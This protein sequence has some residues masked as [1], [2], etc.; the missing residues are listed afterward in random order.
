MLLLFVSSFKLIWIKLASRFAACRLYWLSSHMPVIASSGGITRYQV[1]TVPEEWDSSLINSGKSLKRWH[2]GDITGSVPY[3]DV[4]RS[5]LFEVERPSNGAD[6]VFELPLRVPVEQRRLPHVHVSQENYLDVGL[7]HLRHLGHDDAGSSP[8]KGKL[9][10]PPFIVEKKSC[11]ARKVNFRLVAKS[12]DKRHFLNWS[13]CV[14]AW[15]CSSLLRLL[16]V[17][18]LQKVIEVKQ[19]VG[20]EHDGCFYP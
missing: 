17:S 1:N 12:S 16:A 11:L 20:K 10:S 3:W 9:Y 14:T 18:E 8:S 7:L 19:E 2:E 5:P 4:V 13:W 6:G 15:L